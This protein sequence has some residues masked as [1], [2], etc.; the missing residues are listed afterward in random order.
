MDDVSGA[1]R[2]GD[3]AGAAGVTVRTI[4][5]YEAVGLLAAAERTSAGHRVFGPTDVARLYRIARLRQLG[6]SLDGIRDAL[7]GSEPDALATTLRRHASDLDGQI[8][9]LVRLRGALGAALGSTDPTDDLLTALEEMTVI[10]VLLRH[11]ITQLVYRDLGAAYDHLV[12]VFGLTPREL[13]LGPDD[14]PVHAELFAGDGL[15]WL[16]PE[17]GEFG[18]A[19]PVTTGACTGGAVVLVDDVDEHH[20]HV[21]ERGG[22]VVYP[23]VDQPYGYR[24]YSVRDPEGHLWSFMKP[25]G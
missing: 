22:D 13:T 1:M 24:D 10:D 11:R 14:L 15:V 8:A 19:S 18:L 23:P 2:V 3:L 21:V 5:H 17:S 20:R 25:L 4:H 12:E 6:M 9:R 16:H 7:D